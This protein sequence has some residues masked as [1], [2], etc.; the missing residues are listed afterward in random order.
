[1]G[2]IDLFKNKTISADRFERMMRP[3]I[4][5]LYRFAFRL[6]GSRDDAEELVQSFLTR[7]YQKTDQLE[8]V[9]KLRPWL[10]RGLYNLYVDEY[11]RQSRENILFCK[12]EF[13]DN[14]SDDT[15]TTFNEATN[16]ELISRL[17]VALQ[18]LN[19][20]QR[21]VV[22]LHHSEGYTLE[23]LS[24]ILQVPLGT[25]KSRLHR[26]QAAL[27]KSFTMEPFVEP[28]RVEGIER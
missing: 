22:L 5:P 12:E 14:F 19:H 24:T 23:E 13:I 7:L 10:C 16:S 21:I 26:A 15:D 4:E 25:L 2:I 28:G 8:K 17:E 27:K 1:M 6:C 9:E 3:Q 20:D 18:G 11:R